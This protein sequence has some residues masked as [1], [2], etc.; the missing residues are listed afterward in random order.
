MRERDAIDLHVG[1]RLR[2]RRMSLGMSQEALAEAV[3]LRFQQIQKYEK[4]Q[5]RI[6][7][8]RLFRLAKALRVP[9]DYFFED[10]P[11]V[12]AA[13]LETARLPLTFLNTQE[14]HE[15]AANFMRIRD[16]A[17][18]RKLIELVRSLAEAQ[19]ANGTG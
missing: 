11:E 7:A 1:S 2:Y 16:S 3:G 4:G 9:L 19:P 15:L 13:E 10:L 6:G 8:G 17:T 18:R 5:N 12:D 14:G